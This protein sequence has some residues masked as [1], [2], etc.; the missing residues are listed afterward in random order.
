[1]SRLDGLAGM[2]VTGFTKK[3]MPSAESEAGRVP[4]CLLVDT[5]GSMEEWTGILKESAKKMIESIAKNDTALEKIDLE[6]ITFNTE[7]QISIKIPAQELYGLIDESSGLLKREF[8][9]RL[10]FK[11]QG[12]T[13]TAYALKVAVDDLR[14]RYDTLKRQGKSP[15]SPILFVLS[16]GLPEVH[17][18]QQAEHDQLLKEGIDRIRELVREYKLSVVAVKVGRI[19]GEPRNDWEK[20]KFPQMHQLMRDITGLSDD[21]H[22]CEAKDT[23]DLSK[24]FVFTSTLL[25][26]SAKDPNFDL[27]KMD[28]SRSE[29]R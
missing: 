11:C 6:V 9:T 17:D 4:A 27:N 28:L 18:Y 26:N 23:E 8:Q 19:C 3:E 15:K 14:E 10:D 25:I 24:F 20:Q 12:G 2:T 13:P 1:M 22:V 7:E 16:D 29:L 5:S 21:H